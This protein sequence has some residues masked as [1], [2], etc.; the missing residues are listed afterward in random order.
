MRKYLFLMMAFFAMMICVGFTS[1]SK[2]DEEKNK[3]GDGNKTQ[4][5]SIDG[6][7]FVDL[8]LSVKWS[9]DNLSGYYQYGNTRANDFSKTDNQLPKTNI[10]GTQSDAAYVNMSSK[11]RMPTKAEMQELVDKCEWTI[12]TNN[13]QRSV[14]VKGPSG[15]SISLPMSGAYPLGSGNREVLY[16]NFQCWLMT[17]DL[18]NSGNPRPYVLQVR[19]T[20][21]TTKPDVRVTTNEALRISGIPVRGVS[22]AEPDQAGP[23]GPTSSSIVGAWYEEEYD[24]YKEE[25]FYN[26]EIWNF[27]GDGK[28]GTLVSYF[29]GT[30][31]SYDGD[32]KLIDKGYHL[33]TTE[34]PYTF[35]PTT[36]KLQIV[37]KKEG[38]FTSDVI[39]YPGGEK[40]DIVGPAD[41]GWTRHMTR[42]H[43][44]LPPPEGKLFGN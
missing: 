17:S 10:G 44:T 39:I 33:T 23:G 34:E 6:K 36:N 5:Q 40:I 24:T 2:D 11:W 20:N 21:E 22:T 31:A 7:E 12:V 15:K 38:L 13:G 27:T 28:S 8:G 37:G 3:D 19:Y 25:T 43:G 30:I 1:C 26:Y 4:I 41:W 14:Q 18:D 9:T 42:Y 16:Q 29:L 32:G 35:D